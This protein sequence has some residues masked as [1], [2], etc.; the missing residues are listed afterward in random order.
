LVALRRFV[1]RHG[2]RAYALPVLVV[3]TIAGLATL[4]GGTGSGPKAKAA[5]VTTSLTPSAT[6][7][8]GNSAP[9]S[10][11]IKVDPS[12]YTAEELASDQ[13]PPGADYTMQGKTTFSAIPGTT[14]VVGSGPVKRYV[15]E[16]EDG[17]SGVDVTAFAAAVVATLDDPRS[18]TG[19]PHNVSLQRVATAAQADFRV[20]LTT[21]I[22]VRPACGYDLKVETSCWDDQHGP[23]R[24]YLNLARWV[25]GDASFGQDLSTYHLYMVNH[26]VGHALGHVHTFTCL[27][28]GSAPV[29]MQQTLTLKENQGA[30][31]NICTPN[32]WPY[33][34]GVDPAIAVPS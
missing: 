11:T 16:A 30:G 25:R 13:L 3:V 32:A 29:M 21:S 23:S 14:P 33:P 12:S 5:P 34:V 22:T 24:V 1:R 8:V 18:W 19:G 17:I 27:P 4:G 7:P 6:S 20:S 15:I 31:P 9:A 2:W 10:S 28:N 26:E